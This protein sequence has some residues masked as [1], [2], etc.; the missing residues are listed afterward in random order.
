LTDPPRDGPASVRATLDRH[1][2]AERGA[3]PRYVAAPQF[4]QGAQ[5]GLDRRGHLIARVEIADV[6][7]GATFR[8]FF[9]ANYG[10]T[11]AAYRNIAERPDRIE[12]LDAELAELGDQ[13][14]AGS[15]S[16]EWE[17]LVVT[18]RKR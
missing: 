12:A 18:A 1:V 9:K 7:D 4:D 5:A 14:L 3:R 8:D 17:Y 13:Y 16:M 10:P 11:I 15:S 6:A 2:A